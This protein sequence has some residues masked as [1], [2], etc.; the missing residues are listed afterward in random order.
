MSESNAS[1][2]KQALNAIVIGRAGMDLYPD[3]DGCKTRDADSFTADLGG[4]AGNIA[5]AM[6]CAGASVALL[7]GVSKDPVGDF[8]L[9]KLK[10]FGVNRRLITV[11][12][13]NERTSLALAEVCQDDSEVVIYRNNP[14]DLAFKLTDESRIALENATDL[15][16]TGTSLIDTESR[17][18]TLEAIKIAKSNDCQ[19]WFDLDYRK[20]NWRDEAETRQV[21]SEAASY[22]D[23]IV[24]NEEEFAILNDDVD[25]LVKYYEE[26]NTVIVLK[27]GGAGS[28]V[29]N[30]ATRLDS[31]VYPVTP[32]KPYGAGD[33]FLGNLVASFYQLNDW[34]KAIS[35][36][37]AAAAIVVSKRGCASVMPAA[38]EI[39]Q[40]MTQ[41]Q[42]KPAAIW[43]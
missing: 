34:E 32:L 21:Y 22:C 9:K 13:G 28:S 20:F 38:K 19:I 14:A 26:S 40:L 2:T 24:G 27:R 12:E 5:V 4:S 1:Q 37:S 16:I 17:L 23:V 33:A 7:S 6:S 18:N 10:T 31:G 29:F 42:M 39:E 35:I 30:G 43:R 25:N 11:T 36:G 15:V 8:V 41:Q 3:P